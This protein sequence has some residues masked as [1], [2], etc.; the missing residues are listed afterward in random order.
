MDPWKQN[1]FFC[2]WFQSLREVDYIIKD[3]L[4]FE[5]ILNME[6]TDTTDQGYFYNG[7]YHFVL[8]FVSLFAA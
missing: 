6:F 8:A 3:K 7:K 4:L 5:S 2:W 1:V